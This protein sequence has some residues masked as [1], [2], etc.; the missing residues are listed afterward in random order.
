MDKKLIT[1]ALF[2]FFAYLFGVL[3]AQA[4][5]LNQKSPLAINVAGMVRWNTDWP[6][7]DEMKRAEV[8]TQCI[9]ENC[10]NTN[11]HHKVDWDDNGWPRSLT[12]LSSARFTQI[13]F[14]LFGGA[15][16][17]WDVPNP[18][19]GLFH[20][21]YDGRGRLEYSHGA[22]FV[23]SCG[24]G[25]DLVKMSASKGSDLLA[26]I[27][28][29]ATTLG[30]HLRNI[31]VIWP[32]GICDGDVFTY[33]SSAA[34]CSGQYQSLVDLKDQMIFHPA[35]LSDLKSYKA[36]RFLGYQVANETTIPDDPDQQ[37]HWSDR[38]LP[39]Y[40]VWSDT[41]PVSSRGH[42]PK[43]GVPVEVMVELLN[44]LGA[45][46][47]FT[48][49]FTATDD[50]VQAFA[51]LVKQTLN[52]GQKIYL[53]YGNEAWN[54]AWPF[55][56]GGKWL[57]AKGK[58][59]WPDK[60]TN[61][62][63]QMNWYAKRSTEI[64][65]LWKAEWGKSSGRVACVIGGHA[66]NVW[67]TENLLLKCPLWM[68]DDRNPN[69]GQTCAS[70]VNAVAIAPY[71]GGYIGSSSYQGQVQTWDLNSLFTEIN[72][73]GLLGGASETLGVPASPSR[74]L[75]EA[76]EERPE[77][78]QIP[79]KEMSVAMEELPPEGQISAEVTSGGALNEAR[80]WMDEQAALAQRFGVNLLAYE[81]GQHI[82]GVNGVENNS[83]ITQLF[84]NANRDRRMGD[85]YTRHLSDWSEAGGQLFAVFEAVGPYSKWGSWG[86][87][88]YQNQSNSPKYNAVQQFISDNPCWWVGCEGDD[89]LVS[90]V[91]PDNQWHQVG[92]PL[93]LPDD[94]NTV[95]AVF[96]DD[97]IGQTYNTD[98][99]VYAYDP[100]SG[101]NNLGLNGV[102]KQGVGYWFIQ[103]SGANVT[104]S[105]PSRSRVAPIE[106][107]PECTHAKG[108]FEM[109]LV[110]LAG[111][112][113]WNMTAH[114]FES[115][116]AMNQLRVVTKA[117]TVCEAGCTLSEAK[118][119]GIVLDQFWHY[120][121]ADYGQLGPGDLIKSWYGLWMATLN[122]ADGLE[123]KLLI[124]VSD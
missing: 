69:K 8:V 66:A 93:A 100:L 123:P 57:E 107:S 36:I 99:V 12:P 5:V 85:V 120:N 86:V 108:C 14:V 38:R 41:I 98:W 59:F 92:L 80:G 2:V 6:L 3:Q 117:N 31:R 54:F 91:L 115:E 10:W 48:L 30:N 118:A 78:N 62:D 49:P 45:D 79:A 37:T 67:I 97:L 112:T 75:G 84:R 106:V 55:N 88:E 103:T 43:R 58:Q 39:S 89:A 16:A 113:G 63:R 1:F 121:G 21:F 95:A 33:H 34:T 23:D 83:V 44:V 76:L 72:Q 70:F 61:F 19:S 22:S 96:G 51:R 24:A 65:K 71:L 20:V 81:G 104:L 114:V 64:C 18:P 40:S 102:L 116:V 124:P 60:G 109:P 17:A 110:T 90:Y 53:E 29:R 32:G 56:L 82:V 87:K 77:Q 13:S 35:Y 9:G 47:W 28:I 52:G 94:E 11:E 119:A 42:F 26:L 101:Y 111:K 46:G 74:Y 50:Y 25:C 122:Q 68:N 73:G 105:L 7:I 27:T 4:S 15:Y